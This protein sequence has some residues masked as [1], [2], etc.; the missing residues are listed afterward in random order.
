[1]GPS[2]CLLCRREGT[3]PVGSAS[4][5]AAQ[6][7]AASLISAA[8]LAA[9]SAPPGAKPA[10][11]A[12][13]P[14]L[15]SPA[16]AAVA[17]PALPP[18]PSGPAPVGNAPA[19]L[20][21]APASKPGPFAPVPVLPTQVSALA[22]RALPEPP[23]APA[24]V[25]DNPPALRFSIR[26][27]PLVLV[28]APVVVVAL[29]LLVIFVPGSAPVGDP[30]AALVA[31]DGP[32]AAADKGT[33]AAGEE[34]AVSNDDTAAADTA[35]GEAEEP[36]LPLEL[37][38]KKTAELEKLHAEV[39]RKAEREQLLT[40]A[41]GRLK[42]KVYYKQDCNSCS[43]ARRHLAARGVRAEEHDI[44]QEP[45]A[46]ARHRALN[47]RGRLP[48]IEVEGKVLKGFEAPK[49]DRAIDRAATAR[50]KKGR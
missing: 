8:P 2:G 12:A 11:P 27:H 18:Q 31:L 29:V 35:E 21:S 25:T 33:A 46:R 17:P 30:N 34:Q 32:S 48:T 49:L 38:A 19:P 3:N 39:Q 14:V 26:V 6:A 41:R 5:G 45:K 47:P 1:M 42:V 22:N 24:T 40:A 20:G 50:L 15:P 16:A 23:A 44:D 36:L 43:E 37:A 10:Q 4:S 7:A 13:A 28:L 9:V